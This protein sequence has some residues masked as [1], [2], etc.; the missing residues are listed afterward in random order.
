LELT[1]ANGKK[2]FLNYSLASA[3]KSKDVAKRVTPR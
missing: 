1:H 2:S 3:F